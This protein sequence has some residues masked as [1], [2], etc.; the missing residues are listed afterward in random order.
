MDTLPTVDD[1]AGLPRCALAALLARC[2]RRVQPLLAPALAL[3][4]ADGASA[5]RT[6]L[7]VAQMI[8]AVEAFAKG[9]GLV[10]PPAAG[11]IPAALAAM[12]AALTASLAMRAV[13]AALAQDASACQRAAQCIGTARV[14]AAHW[15]SGCDTL[16]IAAVKRDLDVLRQS[17]ARENWTDDTPV[18]PDAL[19]PLW[20]EG[21]P[22]RWS[23]GGDAA[24][25][26]KLAVRPIYAVDAPNEAITLYEGPL[27]FRTPIREF[28]GQG[29]VRFVWLPQPTVVFEM[30]GVT[31]TEFVPHLGSGVVA[32]P[33]GGF[34]FPASVAGL[35]LQNGTE[36][37]S[38]AFHGYADEP[39]TLGTGGNLSA[40]VFHLANFHT[41]MTPRPEP[42]PPEYDIHRTTFE[43]EG[44]RVVLEAVENT[45]DLIS[46]LDACA[47]CAF[48]HVGRLER[49]DG[50]TFD[51]VAVADLLA[52][53]FY[54]F[55]FA[56]GQWSPALLP[57][58]LDAQGNR[59]WERWDAR[60]TSDWRFRYSWFPEFLPDCLADV[61]PGFMRLWKDPDWKQSLCVAIHWYIESNAQAGAIE[62]TLVLQQLASEL[63]S[64][65][66]F[67]EERGTY[68]EKKFKNHKEFPADRKMRLLLDEAKIP[69]AIPARLAFLSA[70]ATQEGWQDGPQAL[71]HLRN[72]ITHPTA[73][74]RQT[75]DRVSMPARYEAFSLALWYLELI[76][77]WLM[78]YKGD[79][80]NRLNVRANGDRETVPWA[81]ATSAT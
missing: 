39:P 26:A 46:S 47:G 3:E 57:V 25:R 27:A 6:A 64:S 33:T 16:F 62:G 73:H 28:Q 55:S 29:A 20:P 7:A 63:L 24:V 44:W 79:Y 19:G 76:L 58:G 8:E 75:L 37:P 66:L 5:T 69:T 17:A 15:V 2:A 71:S 12:Y 13:R 67:V 49:A 50:T 32:S 80:V 77:L 78:G 21:I 1:L 60:Q 34:V 51:V 38:V 56:R 74:K 41:Y 40:V 68:T 59:V 48:T 23:T 9:G 70:L 30:H 11:S 45:R 43:A 65:R 10:D 36:G 61:F 22:E 4:S 31:P 14:A 42:A 35:E 53:L 52:A 54:F 72:C 81:P 18:S